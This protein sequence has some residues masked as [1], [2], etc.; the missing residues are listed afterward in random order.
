MVMTLLRAPLKTLI[1][2][3]GSGFLEVPL[4][5]AEEIIKDELTYEM[6]YSMVEKIN[7]DLKG[8]IKEEKDA[9]QELFYICEER[10]LS[11]Q[12]A[13]VNHTERI[14]SYTNT[15]L[16]YSGKATR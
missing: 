14:T 1:I 5:N 7:N 4:N 11:P 8:V 2:V 16:F 12:K 6:L 13:I 10:G 3:R 15:A 9:L